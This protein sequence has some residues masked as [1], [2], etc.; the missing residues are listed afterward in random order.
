[1]VKTAP[2]KICQTMGSVDI[3]LETGGKGG[4]NKEGRVK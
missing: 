1:M 3:C 4:R 2:F